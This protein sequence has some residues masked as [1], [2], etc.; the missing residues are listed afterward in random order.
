MPTTTSRALATDDAPVTILYET[1]GSAS[2]PTLLFVNGLGSQCINFRSDWLQM[3][4]AEGFHV[5]RF[6][7][8]D[9]GLSSSV[10]LPYT[11][12]DMAV[13]RSRSS[14]HSR[15]SGHT[16]SACRSAA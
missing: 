3:F 6:D 11:L 9:V 2:D 12:S 1:F 7:N 5:V 13:T 16:S 4:A 14:T 8:R 10:D 15:W